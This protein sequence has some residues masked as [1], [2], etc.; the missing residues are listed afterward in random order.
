MVRVV[1]DVEFV[2]ELR[3]FGD[4]IASE[5]RFHVSRVVVEV[6]LP[7]CKGG[8]VFVELSFRRCMCPQWVVNDAPSG[9]EVP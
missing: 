5:G 7:Q 6:E 9:S 1:S 3:G 4:M 8:G 2:V